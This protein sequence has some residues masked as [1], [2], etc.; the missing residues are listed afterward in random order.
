MTIS[1]GEGSRGGHVIGHTR[2]GK[3]VYASSSGHASS[4]VANYSE[5]LTTRDHKDAALLHKDRAVQHQMAGRSY[6]EHLHRS[7]A[8]V[9]SLAASVRYNPNDS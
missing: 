9:H 3:P 2:S 7:M 5:K 4:D 1:I 8:G 6:Q